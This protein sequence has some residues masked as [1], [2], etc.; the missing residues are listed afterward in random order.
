MGELTLEN[1][2]FWGEG[3]SLRVAISVAGHS[4]WRILQKS[5]SRRKK[6]D[7]FFTGS[8]KL[9]SV[10]LGQK[11]FSECV[12]YLFDVNFCHKMYDSNFY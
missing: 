2:L 7:N 8:K 4:T 12:T 10:L 11:F 5:F 9:K 1:L 3:E 6:T